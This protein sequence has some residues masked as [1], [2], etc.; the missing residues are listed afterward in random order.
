[1]RKTKA[2]PSAVN[3]EIVVDVND[4][5]DG[6]KCGD[7]TAVEVVNSD[8]TETASG[9]NSGDEYERPSDM[10]SKEEW[11]EKERQFAKRLKKKGLTI[12]QMG[13]DGACLFRAVGM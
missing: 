8:A 6:A 4:K 13:E 3:S 7:K 10:W 5:S 11:D 2:L 1:M 9:Y 12:K